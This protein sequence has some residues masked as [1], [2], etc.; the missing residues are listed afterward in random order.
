MHV[1]L[2]ITFCIL[3]KSMNIAVFE[4]L[5]ALLAVVSILNWYGGR[6]G[7]CMKRLNEEIEVATCIVVMWKLIKP[8]TSLKLQIWKKKSFSIISEGSVEAQIEYI[9]D[10]W[11]AVVLKYALALRRNYY[12]LLQFVKKLQKMLSDSMKRFDLLYWKENFD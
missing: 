11:N 4:I 3:I 12:Y 9:K 1:K 6:R 5:F 8:V 7:V 10:L 2:G